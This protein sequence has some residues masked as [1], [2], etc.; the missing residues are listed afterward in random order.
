MEA[1]QGWLAAV[2]STALQW[3][4]IAFVAIN[5]LAAIAFAR[6]RDRALVN[7]WTGP[8]LAANLMLG[9]TGVALPLACFG[10]RAVISAVMP[11]SV[12]SDR[13][14]AASGI[15]AVPASTADNR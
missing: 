2:G 6:R 9:G 1:L 14:S 4:L 13:E 3:S 12:H 11:Q 8:L 5:G 15:I 10:A 7:R